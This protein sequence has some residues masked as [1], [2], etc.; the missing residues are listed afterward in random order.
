MGSTMGL[1]TMGHSSTTH[2]KSPAEEKEEAQA[3]ARYNKISK[4]FSNRRINEIANYKNFKEMVKNLTNRIN[5]TAIQDSK[6]EPV[7]NSKL[8]IKSRLKIITTK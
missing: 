6:N 1:T 7:N 8:F 2:H 3:Q 4:N 5:F